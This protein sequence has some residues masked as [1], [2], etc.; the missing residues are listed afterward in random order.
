MRSSNKPIKYLSSAPELLSVLGRAVAPKSSACVFRD[1][2]PGI[3]AS[4]SPRGSSDVSATAAK[5]RQWPRR[6]C[7][8]CTQMVMGIEGTKVCDEAESL[9][10]WCSRSCWDATTQEELPADLTGAAR[11]EDV[12]FMQDWYV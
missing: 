2:L 5:P 1:A 9:A 3:A 7:V 6:V 10:A 12:N 11:Q 8:G 4:T